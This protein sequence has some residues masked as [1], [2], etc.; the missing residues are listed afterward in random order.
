MDILN[1]KIEQYLEYEEITVND[2]LY[3][4]KKGSDNHLLLG[5][6]SRLL[7]TGQGELVAISRQKKIVAYVQ[8]LTLGDEYK[9][10][11]I[12]FINQFEKWYIE[13]NE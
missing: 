4:Y 10:A 9:Q 6:F 1:A 11:K 7:S 3:K 5:I 12:D 13:N 8:Y 2:K